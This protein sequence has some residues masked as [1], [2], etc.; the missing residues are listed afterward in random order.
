LSLLILLLV[1]LLSN[2]FAWL[3]LLFLSEFHNYF[4]LEAAFGV[5][6]KNNKNKCMRSKRR[7]VNGKITR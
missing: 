6:G 3:A 7:K 5:C 4:E 1:K 2:Q